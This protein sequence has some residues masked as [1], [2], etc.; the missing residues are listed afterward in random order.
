MTIAQRA[1][2]RK[3]ILKVVKGNRWVTREQ[4]TE[5]TGLGIQRIMAVTGHA[6]YDIIGTVRGYKRIG[7]S[8]RTEVNKARKYLH[9]KIYAMRIRS[10]AIRDQLARR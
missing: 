7:Y 3:E 2:D 5:E 9:S 8:T 1:E 10:E 4:I 6:P